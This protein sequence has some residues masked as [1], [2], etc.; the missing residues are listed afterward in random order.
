M[1]KRNLL[2][3]L[4]I[5]LIVGLAGCAEPEP[6]ILQVPQTVE[7]TREVTREITTVVEQVVTQEVTRIVTAEPT[8]TPVPADTPIPTLT[9][10]PSP[11]HST[12]PV[13]SPDVRTGLLQAMRTTR[14][15]LD[16]FGGLIDEAATTRVI[17]CEPTVELFD[18]IVSAPTF[19][20]A[21]SSDTVR[22]AYDRYREAISI[23]SSQ[24]E[25]LAEQCRNWLAD[26]AKDTIEYVG[27]ARA[28]AS[29]NEALALLIPAI[30]ALE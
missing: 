11:T 28:R 30:D 21:G 16:E 12:T 1:Q 19:H 26:D 27:W 4:A 29:V 3:I 14:T 10:S 20:L 7:V 24:S 8:D 2:L 9:P 15:H 22:W 25:G 18:A 17:R 13:P 6:Q 23:Y 5:L